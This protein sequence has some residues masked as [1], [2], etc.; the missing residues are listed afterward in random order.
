M[1][2][3]KRELKYSD[4]M[5]RKSLAKM[6]GVSTMTIYTWQQ[7]ALPYVRIG[8]KTYYFEQSVLEWLKSRETVETEGENT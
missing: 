1:N 6:F 5:D 3:N 2:E 8:S 7:R 4:L